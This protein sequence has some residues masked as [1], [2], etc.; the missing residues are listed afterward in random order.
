VI[1]VLMGLLDASIVAQISPQCGHMP[2][3]STP[4]H[5]CHIRFPPGW[6]ASWRVLQPLFFS[7]TRHLGKQAG[8][9]EASQRTGPGD[10]FLLSFGDLVRTVT[11]TGR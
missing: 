7:V 4:H 3:L 2:S 6:V 11:G 8:Q 5:L 9:D 1:A 10:V